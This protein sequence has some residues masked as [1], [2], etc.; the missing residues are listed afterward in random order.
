MDAQTLTP[1]NAFPLV[2]SLE[3]EKAIRA[4]ALRLVTD[5]T[6]GLL[7]CLYL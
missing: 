1:Q 6:A 7:K 3:D 4:V 2:G 5:E